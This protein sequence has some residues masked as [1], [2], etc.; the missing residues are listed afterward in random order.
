MSLT[1]NMLLKISTFEKPN[2]EHSR[3]STKSWHMQ[4]ETGCTL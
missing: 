3:H 1:I 2:V 4:R